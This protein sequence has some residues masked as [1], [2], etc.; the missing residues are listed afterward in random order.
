[1]WEA[2]SKEFIYAV[3]KRVLELRK[4]NL[5][6]AEIAKII[7]PEFK[8]VK[9]RTLALYASAL[10]HA[11]DMVMKLYDEG[12]LPWITILD[13]CAG[14][15]AECQDI[16]AQEI[17]ARQLTHEDLNEIKRLLNKRLSLFEAIKR[18]TDKGKVVIVP[19]MTKK[20][21][22]NLSCLL[23]EIATMAT[24]FRAKVTMAVELLP[25]SPID[26]GTAHLSIF[27]KIYLLRHILAEQY[28]FVDKRVKHY[29]TEIEKFMSE[30]ERMKGDVHDGNGERSQ[31][32]G[33]EAGGAEMDDPG[34]AVPEARFSPP[35]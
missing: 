33:Q 30:Q 13:L 24:E 19:A 11:S 20:Q 34:S 26:G 31:K 28:E 27:E 2:K 1:M 8:E 5:S 7:A 16:L 12:K 25:Y 4:E 6:L 3:R 23:E 14:K 17:I 32:G 18:V 35:G 15:S 29:L 22:R 21:E 10:S 9:E